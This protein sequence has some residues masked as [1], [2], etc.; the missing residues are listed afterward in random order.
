[1]SEDR[2]VLSDDETRL[3]EATRAVDAYVTELQT[4]VE[5][6]D[7]DAFNA[8]FAAD[9]LWGTPYGETVVGYDAL[10]AVHQRMLPA[11]T[12]GASSRYETVRVSAPAPDVAVAQ[13]H[14]TALND[15]G[16][17]VAGTDPKT[18]SEMTTFVLVRRNREWWLAA[19][20]H[21]PVRPKPA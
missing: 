4:G 5:A 21:T 9:V 16:S 3:A 1:M 13:V 7:A 8:R 6:R 17:P 15:D 11:R 10:H 12:G 2:P 14:R 20:Q 18:F 19:G